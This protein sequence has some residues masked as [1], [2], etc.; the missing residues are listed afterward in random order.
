[1]IRLG[2]RQSVLALAQSGHVARAIG[3]DVEL[4]G[5]TTEG[6]RLVDV[7]LR[8]PIAKGFFTEGLET[9]LRE[10]RFDLAVHS[11][12]DL[13]VAMAP[14]LVLGAIPKRAPAADL[15]IVREASFAPDQPGL[16]LRPG[17]TVGA[18]SPRRM[19]LLQTV[20]PDVTASFL[21][22]N[23]TTRLERAAR[24]DFDAIVLA[25]AGVSRLG[26]PIPDGLVICRLSLTGWPPAPGQGAL[27]IQCRADDAPLLTRL[28]R[29]HDPATEAAVHAERAW[30]SR[31][32]G[33][34]AVPFGA[35]AHGDHWVVGLEVGGVFRV[36]SG[37][38]PGAEAAVDALRDGVG[39]PPAGPMWSPATLSP[40]TELHASA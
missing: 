26:R 39:A 15:L 34:C 30:L 4:V 25:E 27:A 18:S 1:M 16:P 14:G 3:P 24:G 9:G 17:A 19:S 38:G 28:A 21:R 8:G 23:V 13:P 10:G 35:Y 31:L 7:P 2:T 12:K 40:L 5:V 36:A 22:G 32:G 20:R 33:G 37:S 6:D 29:L 11:L